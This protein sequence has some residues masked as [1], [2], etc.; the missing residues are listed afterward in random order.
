MW[1]R[2]WT[3]LETAAELMAMALV[4]MLVQMVML[5]MLVQVVM[6]V[7][8]VIVNN[9]DWIFRTLNPKRSPH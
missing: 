3:S 9:K 7:E 6:L 2:H 8:V 4:V 1:R 5:V